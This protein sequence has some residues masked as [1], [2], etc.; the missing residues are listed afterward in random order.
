MKTNEISRF[1]TLAASPVRF[2]RRQFCTYAGAATLT[3]MGAPAV[4]QEPPRRASDRVIAELTKQAKQHRASLSS[5]TNGNLRFYAPRFAP[6]ESG[7]TFFL[8]QNRAPVLL[9]SGAE[10]DI[11]WEVKGCEV[12]PLKMLF[13]AARC[14]A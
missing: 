5:H 6:N 10:C 7:N 9:P 2:T 8:Y 4:A 1:S 11:W 3:T 13:F 14:I 12:L